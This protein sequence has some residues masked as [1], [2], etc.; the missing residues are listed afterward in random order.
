MLTEHAACPHCHTALRDGEEIRVLPA[1][2]AG[3]LL[4]GCGDKDDTGDTGT[5]T[6]EA[7]ALYGVAVADSVDDGTLPTDSGHGSSTISNSPKS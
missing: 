1:I 5:D 2:L 6:G 4:A 7:V 3:L